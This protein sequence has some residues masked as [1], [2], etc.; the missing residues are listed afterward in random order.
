MTVASQ[1]DYYFFFKKRHLQHVS[2]MPQPQ[3]QQ[4]DNRDIRFPFH[5]MQV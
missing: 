4:L 1:Y 5:L 3:K 2:K